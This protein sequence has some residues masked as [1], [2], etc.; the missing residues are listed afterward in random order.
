MPS[1]FRRWLLI[2]RVP[3][4][5]LVVFLFFALYNRFLLDSNLRNLRASLSIMDSA[6]GVGQAE[7]ALLLVDQ[8]LTAQ[9][10]E[11]ELDL[12]AA[13]AL[14]YAQGALTSDKMDRPPDDA[15]VILNVLG[16]EQA[17]ERPGI[18]MALDGF[19]LSAQAAVRQAAL[20]PRQALGKPLSP[21]IDLARLEEAAQL[22]RKGRL[23]EAAALYEELIKTYPDYTGRGSL[24]LRMGLLFQKSND[25]K[26]ARRFYQEALAE[27]RDARESAVARQML[28]NLAQLGARAGQAKGLQRGL[29]RVEPGEPRQR[30]AFKLGSTLI[31]ASSFD[32]A[33]KAFRESFSADPEGE[34]A[35]PSLFKEAWCLRAAGRIEEAFSR[36]SGFLKEHPGTD[37]AVAAQLQIAEMY[38]A[39]GNP[40]AAG[41]AYER[42]TSMKTT[43]AALTAISYAQAG[44]TYQFDLNDI[45]KAQVLLRDLANKFPASSYSTVGSQLK[46]LQVK[47][48]WL[49]ASTGPGI[50]APGGPPPKPPE[51]APGGMFAAGSP[52]VNWLENFLP[53]FVSVFSDR[54]SKYMEAVGEK[55]LARRF[56][57]TEFGE[58]VVREVQRKFPGQVTNVKTQIHPDGFVGSG[59]VH[60]GILNF[61][62]EAR[63]GIVVRNYRPHAI[64]QGIKIGKFSLPEPLL[65]LL[66]TRVNTTIDQTRYSLKVKE[67]K[68]NEG[69]AWI[70]VEV[71]D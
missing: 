35:V 30:A 65:K 43:D 2:L 23:K 17:S 20:L 58:L 9:M 6:S 15:Q 60:L 53:V 62:V 66:E 64:V 31:R 34:L 52:L 18:L 14:Q 19:V 16:E 63:L 27:I 37:W 67:Y 7:A 3:L 68:L 10:A 28:Q 42:A 47:K 11:E 59:D 22:E 71:A 36:F 13:A 8:N 38:K 54:L 40:A 5:L 69:Y 70:S 24:K 49:A 55:Q 48:G 12:R 51:P 29:T 46:Q 21:E 25:F 33:A 32:E 4:A 61:R 45:G 57:D 39:S 26:Q 1:E 56:T 41:E 44:C 50:T